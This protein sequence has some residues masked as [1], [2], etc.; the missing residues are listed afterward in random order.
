MYQFIET[1]RI[2]KGEAF[3]LDLHEKRMNITRN[4]FWPDSP[5]LK[6]KEILIKT[7]F[8]QYTERTRCRIVYDQNFIECKYYPYSPRP[9]KN[10]KCLYTDQL[11]YRF[12]SADR[13]EIDRLFATR[14]DFDDVLFVRN[15]LITDTSIANIAFWNGQEWHTPKH[16]LLAGTHR[17]ALIKTGEIHPY[18]ITTD[19]LQNYSHACLFNALLDFG[20]IIIETRRISI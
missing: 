17:E 15:N 8:N 6:L 4:F 7:N 16:P 18:D 9:I 5:E 11:Q 10:L 2:E 12:K 13:T 20:E 19:Q 1:I 3:R 14:E